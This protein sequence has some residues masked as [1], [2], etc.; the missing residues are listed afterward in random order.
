MPEVVF[1]TD[2]KDDLKSI[3]RFTRKKWSK[4]QTVDYV[5]GLRRQAKNLAETPEIGK[6][7]DDL[8]NG[9]LSFHYVSHILFYIVE[10]HGITIV[11]VLHKSQDLSTHIV[12]SGSK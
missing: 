12:S 2:S 3:V 10:F 11:R 6:K 5:G 8:A 1:S 4:E 9:L 7:R